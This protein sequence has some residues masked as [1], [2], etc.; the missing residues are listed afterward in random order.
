MK[1]NK[2]PTN[3][4]AILRKHN[5]DSIEINSVN[6]STQVV[7]RGARKIP[8]PKTSRITIHLPNE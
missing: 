4:D 5:E 8:Q 6:N 7:P 1:K 2:N 3:T